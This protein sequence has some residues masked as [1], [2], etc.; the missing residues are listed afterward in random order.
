MP[1]GLPAFGLLGGSFH[2]WV[3]ARVPGGLPA[4]GLLGGSLHVW[5]G[6][7]VPGGLPAFGFSSDLEEWPRVSARRLEC[8]ADVASWTRPAAETLLARPRVV[9][10]TADPDAAGVQAVIANAR[11]AITANPPYRIARD[12]R[13]F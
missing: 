7:R 3:G 1:G 11:L 10:G 4:F 12:F 5:V 2:V 13:R 6:A 9:T 8:A